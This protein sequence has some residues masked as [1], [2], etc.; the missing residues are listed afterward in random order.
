MK[1][2]FRKFLIYSAIVI[3]AEIILLAI[4]NSQLYLDYTNQDCNCTQIYRGVYI[5]I[6]GVVTGVF[7][8]A[9]TGK[10]IFV[11]WCMLTELQNGRKLISNIPLIGIPYTPLDL[12]VL[13]DES[14]YEEYRNCAI[15]L[16]D[17]DSVLMDNRLS[18]SSKNR[19]I[20]YFI[21]NHGKLAT[22]IYYTAR[23]L[24]PS[25]DS[26]RLVGYQLRLV[27][28]RLQVF[29]NYQVF[30]KPWRLDQFDIGTTPELITYKVY[31]RNSEGFLLQTDRPFGFDKSQIEGLGKY[32]DSQRVVM[33]MP[34]PKKKKKDIPLDSDKL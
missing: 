32:F 3:I 14:R 4:S 17:V 13:I 2:N 1:L 26:T 23:M 5:S 27:D 9:R 33:N 22:P 18:S 8:D 7:G 11:S 10:S 34:M 6:I 12:E 24:Q 20:S 28:P 30:P 21:V 15:W 31:F 16:D 19:L 29:S 25:P